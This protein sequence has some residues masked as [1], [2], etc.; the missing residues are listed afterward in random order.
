MNETDSDMDLTTRCPSCGTVF[1][2]S[3]QDLQLRK[4]YIR[5]VQCAHIFDGYAEVVSDSANTTDD[6]PR[7][8]ARIE[9]ELVEHVVPD[10]V[11][12]SVFRPPREEPRFTVGDPGDDAA[13]QPGPGRPDPRV[14]VDSGRG[15]VVDAHPTRGQAYGGSAAP[16]LR[17]DEGGL[18]QQMG[19]WT[20]N[21]L[22]VL[23]LLLLL[24]QLAYVY[25]SQ[26][27]LAVPSMRPVLEG[28]CAALSCKVPYA[29]DASQLVIT[30]SDLKL[31]NVPEPS[32]GTDSGKQH[33]ELSLTLRNRGAQPSMW[34]SLVLDLN[35]SSGARVVRRNL[36]PRDYLSSAQLGKPFPADSELMVQ[37]PLTVS[38]VRVIGFEL[39]LFFS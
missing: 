4:G 33:F 32:A 25:R 35:D 30:G 20:L 2:A 38:G 28:A 9:P 36:H 1:Q 11:P 37:V 6:A 5:C 22:V 23:G 12:P 27:A 21:L 29:R 17:Q 16:L 8:H 15:F 19:R 14:P 31:D 26:I 18:L 13:L 39:T 34:P 7:P 10:D 24:A 3:L